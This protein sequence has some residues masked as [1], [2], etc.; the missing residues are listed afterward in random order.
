MDVGLWECP[1]C[2]TPLRKVDNVSIPESIITYAA[3]IADPNNSMNRLVTEWWCPKSEQCIYS[4][5]GGVGILLGPFLRTVGW[6]ELL[7]CRHK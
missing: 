1:G 2:G 4:P 7:P 6:A 5:G 3:G